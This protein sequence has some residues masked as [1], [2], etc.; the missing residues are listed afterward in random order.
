MVNLVGGISVYVH[1]L[2]T[3]LIGVFSSFNCCE[4]TRML[5]SFGERATWEIGGNCE[6]SLVLSGKG[7]V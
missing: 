6:V 5:V 2:A 3:C 4:R 1:L 7:S